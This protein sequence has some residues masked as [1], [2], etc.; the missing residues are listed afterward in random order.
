MCRGLA[1]RLASTLSRD[2]IILVDMTHEAQ[3]VLDEALRL[4]PEEQALLLRE[5]M[6]RLEGEPD[7]D[8]EAAWAH[9][10]TQR[11]AEARSGVAP[12]DDW[13]TACDAIE[14]ELLRR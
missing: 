13:Q 12:A 10:I 3:R 11:A 9:E 4:A 1:A 14:A 5:L 6:A 7:P 8:A 2:V